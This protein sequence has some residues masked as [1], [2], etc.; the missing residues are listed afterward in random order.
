[1]SRERTRLLVRLLLLSAVSSGVVV[2]AD[3]GDVLRRVLSTWRGRQTTPRTVHYVLSGTHYVKAGALT[4][5]APAFG[6]DASKPFPPEDV[7]DRMSIKIWLDLSKNRI[8][9]DADIPS[10]VRFV[11]RAAGDTQSREIRVL[12]GTMCYVWNP[13]SPDDEIELSF[14]KNVHRIPT[15]PYLLPIRFA[16]GLV[17]VNRLGW[18]EFPVPAPKT[19]D[20]RVVAGANEKTRRVVIRSRPGRDGSWSE[21][22]L[23]S[24]RVF[25]VTRYTRFRGPHDRTLNVQVEYDDG[26]TNWLPVHWK[27]MRFDHG[28]GGLLEAWDVVVDH[29]QR[30][31]AI[32]GSVFRVEPAPG[33]MVADVDAGEVYEVS[34][35]GS[36]GRSLAA[37]RLAER[38]KASWWAR[39]RWV[40]WMVAS[41]IVLVAT[42]VVWRVWQ[43]GRS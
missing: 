22:E 42:G 40:L 8:R 1:M 13:N 16:H 4:A 41:G 29:V 21:W 10:L 34:A 6:W 43:S 28:K 24:A 32:G 11:D 39:N 30:D 5:M 7:A 14:R 37:I 3:E 36:K 35:D 15:P 26:K 9:I 25:A 23:D 33:M 2:R 18:L 19:G 27:A 31:V 17:D 20:F 12:D 38:R